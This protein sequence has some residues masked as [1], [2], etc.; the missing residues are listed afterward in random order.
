MG[1]RVDV[2]VEHSDRLELVEAKS[3]ETASSSLFASGIRV[4]GIS[5]RDRYPAMSSRSKPGIGGSVDPR[6]ASCRGAGLAS[7]PGSV[8]AR[9]SQLAG[10]GSRD[11]RRHPPFAP[12]QASAVSPGGSPPRTPDG[13]A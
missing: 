9:A 4:K 6:L 13:G 1:S 5:N 8:E 7:D 12:G 10:R 2:V 11:V 3:A